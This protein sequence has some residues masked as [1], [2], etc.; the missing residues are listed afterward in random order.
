LRTICLS[1]INK[2]T[3]SDK[4]WSII[5]APGFFGW[6]S[7]RRYA[8]ITI[9]NFTKKIILIGGTHYTG[10]IKRNFLCFKLLFYHTNIRFYLCIKFRLATWVRMIQLYF[11]GLSVRQ[12]PP[13]SRCE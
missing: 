8:S 11:F 12:K 13:I 9:I 6:S 10:E 2:I 7:Y 3:K 1:L 4:D 5:A